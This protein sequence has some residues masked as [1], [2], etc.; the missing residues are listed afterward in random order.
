MHK[1]LLDLVELEKDLLAKGKAVPKI[2]MAIVHPCSADSLNGVVNAV[3]EGLIDPI[4]IAPEK[5][6]L[7]IAKENKIDL[8]SYKIINV[9]HSE[10]AAE[11]A[12]SLV[13]EGLAKAIMKGSLHTDELMKEVVKRDKGL[14]TGRRISHV[15]IMARET[16]HKPFIITDA[17]ININPD[18]MTKRDIVQNAIDLMHVFNKDLVPKVGILSAVETINP[19]IQSTID[20]AC[21]CK[22]ADRGQI[23]GGIVDGPFAYDNVIS[24]RAAETKKIK[25]KVIGDVDIYLVPNLEAGNMLAKQLAFL[26]NALSAGLILGAKVP[27]VLTSRSDGVRS[28]I[29]SC[30]IAVLMV[31]AKMTHIDSE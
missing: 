15:F 22:M 13:H 18:L 1:K 21:L 23:T 10:A 27:I 20:A 31:N 4:L 24:A 12:V 19:D 16:Y 7:A 2:T 30:I 14:R 17:A 5:K 28:R 9:P 8:T 3:K 6:L 11:T 26:T 25:S 29:L